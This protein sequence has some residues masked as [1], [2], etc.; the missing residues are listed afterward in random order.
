MSEQFRAPL[1]LLTAI[2]APAISSLPAFGIGDSNGKVAHEPYFET[3]LIPAGY[4]FS[5]WSV[6]FLGMIASAAY[7]CFPSQKDNQ[8]FKALGWNLFLTYLGID[9]WALLA[10]GLFKYWYI[11]GTVFLFTLFF[12]IKALFIMADYKQWDRTSNILVWF[13]ISLLAGWCN[14]ACLLNW[15]P[16]IIHQDLINRDV[17]YVFWLL[18][19]AGSATYCTKRANGNKAYAGTICWAL[20]AIA[21]A[22]L[23]ADNAKTYLAVISGV[24]VLY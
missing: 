4:A 17:L 6:I 18:M 21:V 12:V 14:A 7:W 16:I 2:L 24:G 5:I 15:A 19:L 9:T 13:P 23:T 1:T 10:L 11:L 20:I 3:P 8:L 22:N